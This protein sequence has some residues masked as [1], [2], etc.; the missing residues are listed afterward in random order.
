MIL[1]LVKTDKRKY[2]MMKEPSF[3]FAFH[4]FVITL[5]LERRYKLGLYKY[6]KKNKQHMLWML[7]KYYKSKGWPPS[8]NSSEEK[9]DFKFREHSS[10]AMMQSILSS[11]S[12]KK[13]TYDT[14]TRRYRS[15]RKFGGCPAHVQQPRVWHSPHWL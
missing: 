2:N 13:S 4:F 15:A 10:L 3:L 6:D 9:L 8:S 12:E 7:F 11:S 1:K 14:S 5:I